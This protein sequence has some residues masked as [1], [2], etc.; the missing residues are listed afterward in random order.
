[1][2]TGGRL[3]TEAW[4]WTSLHTYMKLKK[5]EIKLSDLW[6]TWECSEHWHFGLWEYRGALREHLLLKDIKGKMGKSC[7][8]FN[9]RPFWEMHHW[10]LLSVWT[11]EDV[12]KL[13]AAVTLAIKSGTTFMYPTTAHLCCHSKVTGVCFSISRPC[14]SLNLHKGQEACRP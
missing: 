10:V 2:S 3:F 6:I 14:E 13:T 4:D 8:V 7:Q 9:D 1:M 12:L 5:R 11:S